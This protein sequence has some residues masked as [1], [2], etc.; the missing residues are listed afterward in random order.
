MRDRALLLVDE[1]N[2]YWP[3]IHLRQVQL[4]DRACF[5]ANVQCLNR[6]F[7]AR[8]V[9]SPAQGITTFPDRRGLLNVCPSNVDFTS[10]WHGP[11]P[12]SL[13]S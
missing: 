7:V 3:L 5:H 1:R 6:L 2:D 10:K 13:T 9:Q 11:L 8:L 12:N 4:L